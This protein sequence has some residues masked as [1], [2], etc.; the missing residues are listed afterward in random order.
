MF[1]CGKTYF[2]L[3][4]QLVKAKES[5]YGDGGPWERDYRLWEGARLLKIMIAYDVLRVFLAGQ[6][7]AK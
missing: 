6:R 2:P 5:Q 1:L 7:K 4:T 3:N